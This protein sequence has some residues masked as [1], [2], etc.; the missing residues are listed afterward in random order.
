MLE[1]IKMTASCLD[2]CNAVVNVAR[3]GHIEEQIHGLKSLFICGDKLSKR[4]VRLVKDLKYF[5]DEIWTIGVFTDGLEEIPP[6]PLVLS[7]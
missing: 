3:G 5:P 6:Y 7:L 4:I 2:E 1:E